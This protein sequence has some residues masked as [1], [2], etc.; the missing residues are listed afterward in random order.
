M[1]DKIETALTRVLIV[2]GDLACAA[3]YQD[4]L[5]NHGYH[6][7]IALPRDMLEA[8]SRVN[9]Q[10]VLCD[11][12]NADAR[13]ANLPA[14][15]FNVRPDVLCIAMAKR[16]DHRAP[17]TPMREGACDFIDKSKG[18]AEL[19]PA[20]E[21]CFK[22]RE[23][24]RLADSSA[25]V[26]KSAKNASEDA[27]RAKVEFLAKISHELRTPLNAIIGFSELMIRDVLGPL[28]NEQYRSY[29]GD[30]HSSGR[31]LLDIINDILDFAKAEAGQLLLY[32][33]D[34]DV[35]QVII[36]I[37]R[38]MGPRARDAGIT[39][40]LHVPEELPL[41]W[42]DERKVKQMLLNLVTN[43][44][45]FTPAGGT[46]DV[47]AGVAADGFFLEVSDSGVGIPEHDLARVLEPFVQSDTTLSRRQE[48]T[49]LGLAL[50]KAMIEI[51][52]GTLKLDSE[53]G[54]GTVVRLTF[55]KERV[56][57]AR[58]GNPKRESA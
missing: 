45:K 10:V 22:K 9:P 52:G 41:L 8:I 30:I 37:E 3:Q 2:D 51:H 7:T 48:G 28:G 25:D 56:S 18:I 39:L 16:P 32:E 26:L 42:C 33:S 57:N 24:W 13:G 44:V 58:D 19:I 55:P 46:I 15:V 49:G 27:N 5:Q 12:E 20:I 11:I 1:P 29:V 34:A 21:S 17:N 38:L 31:H 4:H 23:M 47:E 54:K 50:V 53:L 43:A 35:I 14:Q 36:G 40:S 6:V